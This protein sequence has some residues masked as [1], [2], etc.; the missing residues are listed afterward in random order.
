MPEG[1]LLHRYARLHEAKLAGEVVAVSSPQGRFDDAQRLDGLVLE[2]AEAYGK[3]L[4][5][6]YSDG[7]TVHVHLGMQGLFLH[8]DPPAPIAKAQV[9]MRVASSRLVADLIAPARCERIDVRA[10]AARIAKLGPDP[11]RADADRERA[12]EAMAARAKPIGALLLDDT[13]VAGVGNVLR[14]EVLSQCR[15]SPTRRGCELSRGELE[16]I[17]STLVATM[18]RA[19]EDGRILSVVPDGVDRATVPEADTRLVYQATCR[20]CGTPVETTSIGG[21]TSYRCPSCQPA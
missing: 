3:H 5:H 6:D 15:I 11:L 19:V 12:L 14:A 10:R 2:R 20:R 1:H 4:F 13:V 9:R 18:Q 17:W 16:T 7:S 8:F 21:R